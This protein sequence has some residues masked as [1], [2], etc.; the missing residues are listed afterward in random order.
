MQINPAKIYLATVPLLLTA[1]IHCHLS[2][3]LQTLLNKLLLNYSLH[4]FGHILACS[5]P[6]LHGNIQ[7]AAPGNYAPPPPPSTILFTAESITTTG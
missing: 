5:H 1:S 4:F 7:L 6:T 3:L 2:F